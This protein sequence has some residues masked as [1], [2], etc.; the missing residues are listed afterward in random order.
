M[1][2]FVTLTVSSS[3]PHPQH[4]PTARTRSELKLTMSLSLFSQHSSG[5]WTPCCS[6][7][8]FVDH[9]M[10]RL[11]LLLSLP[12]S[13]SLSSCLQRDASV[14]FR[15]CSRLFMRTTIRWILHGQCLLHSRDSHHFHTK[16]T[17]PSHLTNTYDFACAGGSLAVHNTPLAS[18]LSFDSFISLC[19]GT[20]CSMTRNSDHPS[21]ASPAETGANQVC[22]RDSRYCN[23]LHTTS[24]ASKLSKCVLS[25]LFHDW[26]AN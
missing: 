23:E 24:I 26:S 16:S 12:E 9:T 8:L 21:R 7:E 3:P 17:P 11:H 22:E 5:S 14:E 15:S 13:Y 4:E 6:Q 25:V 19:T 10:H 1:P 18:R 20:R 2:S